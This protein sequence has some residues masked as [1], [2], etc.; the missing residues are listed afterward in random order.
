MSDPRISLKQ[1]WL[2]GIL[3]FLL[4]G[5]G[6]LYQGRFFKAA[7]YSVCILGLFFTGMAVAGWQAVQ[8]PTQ[9]AVKQ[10]KATALL[11][12]GAQSAVGAPALFGLLQRER[13]YN[14][15]NV[16]ATSLT[17]PLSA[18]F[19]GVASFQDDAGNHAGEVTGTIFLEPSPEQF[20]KRSI[21]G[22]F[23]GQLSG[24]PI[25]FQLSSHVQLARPIEANPRRALAAGIISTRDGRPSEL[26]HLSGS[27]PRSFWNWVEVPMDDAEE[28]GL[29]GRL[30]KYHEL[31][32][33]FTW[34][35]G[36]LNILAIWDAVEGPAYGYGDE[37]PEP[38]D[39]PPTPE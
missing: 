17:S 31:A 10:R 8:P 9:D 23:V 39:P 7:I 6:H 5:A 18:P 4:P 3:A 19:E 12:Y 24:Q 20:G 35:A 1:P 21:T 30:G 2:A 32:M 26:G 25:E 27:I 16:P 28:Q 33:V 37:Q 29:H 34:V 13:Y 22:R 15:A 38:A 11:K 36:L 14:N